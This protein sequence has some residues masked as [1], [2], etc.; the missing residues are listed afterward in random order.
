MQNLYQGDCAGA[1]SGELK[2]VASHPHELN[3][4]IFLLRTIWNQS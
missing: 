2:G 4:F 3:R 1:D